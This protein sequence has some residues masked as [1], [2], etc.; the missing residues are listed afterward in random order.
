VSWITPKPD[1]PVAFIQGSWIN[2]PRLPPF[3]EPE[4]QSFIDDRCS[5]PPL[6]FPTPV[7]PLESIARQGYVS[8][9][10][11]DRHAPWKNRRRRVY[12]AL[13]ATHA[14]ENRTAR[15][16]SCGA[17][18]WV[19]RRRDDHDSIKIV[20]DCC[21]DRFCE[22][23][24][25][26]RQFTIRRN[27]QNKIEPHP[28]RFLTLT[29][30]NDGVR[31]ATLLDKLLRCFKRLR[32]TVFWKEKVRGGAAFIELS[33]NQ[34]NGRWHPHLHVLLDGKYI[35]QRTL[36]ELWLRITGDSFVLDVRLIRDVGQVTDYITKYATKPLPARIIDKPYLLE[37]A[38]DALQGRKLCYTFGTWSRWALLRTVTDDE[39]ET[40]CHANEIPFRI[41]RPD[42]YASLIHQALMQAV[43]HDGPTAFTVAAAD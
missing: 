23:C 5:G 16:A 27:L 9:A 43:D 24:G 3:T 29:L 2:V 36:R 32:S 13:V 18:F 28:H 1:P 25:Q 10:Y 20:R 7:H 38:I 22:A 8:P 11:L 6:S 41:L 42:D 14:S 40:L 34:E 21:H 4:L 31:L 17:G 33:A 39:W 35:D 19:L 15:F 12:D 30:K 26:T 37:E